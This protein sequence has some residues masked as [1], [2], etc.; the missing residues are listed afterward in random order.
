[1]NII[2]NIKY[3]IRNLIRYRNIIWQTRE[4]DWYYLYVL[5]AFKCRQMSDLHRDYG[6]AVNAEVVAAELRRVAEVLERLAEDTYMVDY[7]EFSVAQQEERKD[8]EFVWGK[9]L[10][11]SKAWRD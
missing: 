7:H 5:I 3:G 11:R 1:M 8:M 9:F 4:W 6:S 10:E 2:R